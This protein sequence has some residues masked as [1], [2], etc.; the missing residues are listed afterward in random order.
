[1]S[2]RMRERGEGRKGEKLLSYGE[3]TAIFASFIKHSP[4]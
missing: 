2:G 4:Q 1:M 3:V